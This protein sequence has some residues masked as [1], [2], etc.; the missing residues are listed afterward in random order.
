M[1]PDAL[2]TD[3]IHKAIIFEDVTIGFEGLSVLDGVS[4]ALRRGETKVLLGVSAQARARS[5][6]SAWD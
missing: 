3:T 2:P 4:F 5:S 6:S 1:P